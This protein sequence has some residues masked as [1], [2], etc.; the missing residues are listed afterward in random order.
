MKNEKFLTIVL[1]LLFIGAG[2]EGFGQVRMGVRN[3]M[4]LHSVRGNLVEC[5]KTTLKAEMS[6]NTKSSVYLSAGYSN[7]NRNAGVDLIQDIAL[8]YSA[9]LYLNHYDEVTGT[10]VR[11]F[12]A[13]YLTLDIGYLYSF[14]PTIHWYFAIELMAKNKEKTYFLDYDFT[15]S[16]VPEV[17]G[18]E[19]SHLKGMDFGIATHVAFGRRLKYLLGVRYTNLAGR[20]VLDN[21]ASR[22]FN[23]AFHNHA[24]IF[25]SGFSVELFVNKFKI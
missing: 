15:N 20:E 12:N 23:E 16:G 4:G 9:A 7:L 1:T 2:L 18:E 19:T 5:N 8:G 3:D 24:L 17:F 21:D 13:Q 10:L 14:K 22:L 25:D 6:L 11:Q